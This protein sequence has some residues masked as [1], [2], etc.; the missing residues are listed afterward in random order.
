[1]GRPRRQTRPPASAHSNHLGART[2]V[3]NPDIL[4]RPASSSVDIDFEII[5]YSGQSR[6]IRRAATKGYAV[7]G[8]TRSFGNLPVSS[9]I[10]ANGYPS[11]VQTHQARNFSKPE[12]LVSPLLEFDESPLGKAYTDFQQLGRRLIAT[13]TPPS[14]VADTGPVDVTLFF[15]NRTP[16]DPV[17]ASTWAAEMLRAFRGVLADELLLACAVCSANLMRWLL[18]PTAESYANIPLVARPTRLQTM[19]PHPAWIDLMIFPTFRN[20]LVN[21]LRDWVGPCTQAEWQVLWSRPLE[22]ALLQ[23]SATGRTYLNSQFTSYVVDPK[24]WSMRRSILE[25]FPDIEGSEMVILP[26]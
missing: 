15:R 4:P 7:P 3:K 20:A 16:D 5:P 13:G 18:V 11:G 14:Q 10:T 19:K 2:P 17:N 21:K 25:D 24:N 12:Y 8:Y 9:A 22:D 6:M 23:D 1:M 26:D